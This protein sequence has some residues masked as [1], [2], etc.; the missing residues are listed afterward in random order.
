M[1]LLHPKQRKDFTISK[2]T[3]TWLAGQLANG[4]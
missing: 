1:P 4:R 2:D 3:A